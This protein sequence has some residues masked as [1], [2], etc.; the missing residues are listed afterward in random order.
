MD[1]PRCSNPLEKKDYKGITVDMCPKCQGLWLDYDELDQLEDTVFARDDLKGTV[2][3]EKLP[4]PLRC[5]K[6]GKAMK[7]F[8]YRN[9]DLVLDVCDD[10]HGF[11]L[12]KGEETKVQ[13]LMREEVRRLARSFDLDKKWVDTLRQLKSKNFFSKLKDLWNA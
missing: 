12:D 11:W 9:Y 3:F 8:N 5:A 6:C 13:E 10:G 1:C 4:S 7:Q 2:I